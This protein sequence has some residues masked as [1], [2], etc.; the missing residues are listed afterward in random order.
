MQNLPLPEIPVQ[1]A[2][3]LRQLWVFNLGIK[4]LQTG[5]SHFYLYHEGQDKKG[6]NEICSLLN[7]YITKN[8]PQNC[9]ELHIFS[10]NCPG[11]NKNNTVVRFLMTL[12]ATGRFEKIFQYFPVC[13]HSFLP[14]DR[15]FGVIKRKLKRIDHIYTPLE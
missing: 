4:N 8:I 11:Q 12:V 1:E 7:E 6:P 3:Y 5:K 9:K 13:G 15:D 10:D 14:C 2:F